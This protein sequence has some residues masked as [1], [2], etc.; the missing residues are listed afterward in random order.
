MPIE[1]V[2]PR[3]R[4]GLGCA[5]I[6]TTLALSFAPLTAY[7]DEAAPTEPAAEAT[8]AES[9][10]PESGGTV[11]AEPEAVTPEAEPAPVEPAPAEPAPA[12]PAP[13]EPAPAEP[14]P[15]PAEPAAPVEVVVAEEDASVEETLAEEVDEPLVTLFAAESGAESAAA[16]E[17]AAVP[18]P[19]DPCYP[20]VCITN[21]TI[22][23]AVNPTG[24]LNTDD[25]TGSPA[26]PGDAGLA[27]LPTGSDSTSPGCLCEG[28]GV[29][30]PASGVWGGANLASEGPGGTNLV[31]ESFEYTGST[32]KSVVVVVDDS[33]APVFRVTHEYV[34]STATPN[35]YQVNVTIENLSGEAI[36]TV[37][38]RRVMDWDIEPTAFDEFV[39]IDGGS[40]SAL[41]YTSDDGFASPNPLSGPASILFEG[42]AV[43]SGPDDHGA[44]FDFAFGPL[45]IGGSLS[46]VIFYGAAATEAEAIAAL[47]AVGAEAY[48]FGQTSS[49]P[50]GG[51]P[52]TFIF[53]FGK[54]GGAPIFGE[55]GGPEEPEP[56]PGSSPASDGGTPVTVAAA[57]TSGG[58]GAS[59]A[60]TG[61]DTAPALWIAVWALLA[62]AAAIIVARVAARRA[63]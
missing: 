16:L 3:S 9:T 4:L 45:G 55:P 8:T 11:P 18:A 7:A 29:G 43:D 2:R 50:K 21:G 59:L 63:D 34:P 6:A 42:D 15:A 56:G 27:Y 53:A 36:A 1:S 17:A 23:L 5:V 22:L 12:E 60:S 26:G 61:T 51:T 20:A 24:E 28:W 13:A 58:V 46:F 44:L 35:L 41:F 39:T 10:A 47:A 25:A 32:A 48:S 19:G 49:D 37:Q 14:A 31:L 62:G 38:Y 40:A 33:D 54:V 52:N 30:D 57:S